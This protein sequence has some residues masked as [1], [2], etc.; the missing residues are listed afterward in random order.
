[1]PKTWCT[2]PGCHGLQTFSYILNI[3]G[4]QSFRR[5]NILKYCLLL[6]R[7]V[8]TSTIQMVQISLR[9]ILIKFAEPRWKFFSCNWKSLIIFSAPL[10]HPVEIYVLYSSSLARSLCSN[11]FLNGLCRARSLIFLLR[12]ENLFLL[13]LSTSSFTGVLL[14]FPLIP[15]HPRLTRRSFFFFFSLRTYPCTHHVKISLG[16]PSKFLY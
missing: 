16:A 15:N 13:Y 7:I 4:H 9:M 8:D 11:E 3:S 12:D 10:A 1:M 2:P 6:S 5:T 14:Q